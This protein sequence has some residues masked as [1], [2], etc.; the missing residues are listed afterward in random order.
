M[1]RTAA[2]AAVDPLGSTLHLASSSS[3]SLQQQQL[4]AAAAAAAAI[5][6]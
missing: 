5:H 3:S 4:A 2:T 1:F 6:S